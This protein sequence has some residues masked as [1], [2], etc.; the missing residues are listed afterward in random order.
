MYTLISY[1]R[2]GSHSSCHCCQGESWESEFLFEENLTNEQLITTLCDKWLDANYN[3][4]DHAEWNFIILRNGKRI[5][6]SI[7]YS[8]PLV[9]SFVYA[10]YSGLHEDTQAALE[11]EHIENLADIERIFDVAKAR[12]ADVKFERVRIKALEEEEKLE[13]ERV[14]TLENKRKQ[15][16][17]LKKELGE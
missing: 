13:K 3:Y 17:Q 8:G 16:E 9:C 10:E 4:N 12:V 15:F 5:Y 2:S 11:M 6:D 1:M 14:K 7:N